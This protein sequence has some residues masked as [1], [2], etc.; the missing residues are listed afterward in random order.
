[1]V[2]ESLPLSSGDNLAIPLIT[3]AMLTFIL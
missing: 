3:G 2:I 1:M